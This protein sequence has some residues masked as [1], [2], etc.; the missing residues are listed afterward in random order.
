[1]NEKGQARGDGKRHRYEQWYSEDGHARPARTI[2]PYGAQ[3]LT[4]DKENDNEGEGH[5]RE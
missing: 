2:G 3:H 4:L 1:M 5:H